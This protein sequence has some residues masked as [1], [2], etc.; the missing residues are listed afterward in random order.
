MSCERNRFLDIEYGMHHLLIRV[1]SKTKSRAALK[2]VDHIISRCETLQHTQ[3]IYAFNFLKASLLLQLHTVRDL[4]AALTGLKRVSDLAR[5]NND[6]EISIGALL[7]QSSIHLSFCKEDSSSEA[8]R[9]LA[10]ARARLSNY[11][12]SELPHLHVLAHQLDLASSL[13]PYDYHQTQA[14]LSAMQQLMDTQLS[15]IRWRRDRSYSL[16]LNTTGRENLVTDTGG[17]FERQPDQGFGLTFSWLGRLEAY[18]LGFLLSAFASF[19]KNARDR[20]CELYLKEALKS[21]SDEHITQDAPQTMPLVAASEKAASLR[22]MRCIIQYR[23]ALAFCF[24]TDWSSAQSAL[25]QAQATASCMKTASTHL[26]STA[27][28][29]QGVIYQGQ[30]QLELALSKFRALHVG[31][32]TANVTSLT[33]TTIISILA[34]LNTILIIHHPSHPQ[35]N[36]VSTLMEKLR[37]FFPAPNPGDSNV[38]TIALQHPDLNSGFHLIMAILQQS[39]D[40]QTISDLKKDSVNKNILA[41]KQVLQAAI[42]NAQKANNPLLKTLCLCYMHHAFFG[43]IVD[44]QAERIAQ[45]SV[46]QAGET[47]NQ[48]WIDIATDKYNRVKSQQRPGPTQQQSRVNDQPLVHVHSSG[49]PS[50]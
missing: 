7:M 20:K 8:Q 43:G 48:M 45:G 22:Q 10:S 2:H 4:H 28:Y 38:T 34:A 23:L 3:W 21:T 39:R 18:A 26:A 14:K 32:D 12:P 13:T 42:N 15:G 9:A 17:V 35:H 19:Q 16:R 41:L 31:L 27:E 30:G 33:F 1:L 47:G 36:F 5:Q 11:S 37:R 24:R 40:S 44:H 50:V 46:V 29:L 6:G 49:H 25:Q